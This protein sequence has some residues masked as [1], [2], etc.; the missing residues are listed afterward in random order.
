MLKNVKSAKKD[1]MSVTSEIL[2][3]D[4]IVMFVANKVSKILD[5]RAS[6]SNY[7]ATAQNPADTNQNSKHLVEGTL[8]TAWTSKL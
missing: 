4:R 6:K 1:K 2:W 3:V 8:V 5:K 7:V